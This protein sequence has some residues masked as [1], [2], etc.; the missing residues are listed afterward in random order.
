MWKFRANRAPEK[1]ESVAGA[2]HMR[3]QGASSDEANLSRTSVASDNS[4]IV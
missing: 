4:A 2:G 1:K 3:Q